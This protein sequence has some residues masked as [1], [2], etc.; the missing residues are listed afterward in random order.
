MKSSNILEGELNKEFQTVAAM[1]AIYCRKHHGGDALC[2]QC[3]DLLKYAESKLDGCPYGEAKPT[4]RKCP[5]HCYRPEPKEQMRRV[6]LY[7]G[8]RMLLSHP[9]LAIR[10][11]LHERKAVPER[12][13]RK[14]SNR[15]RRRAREQGGSH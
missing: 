12:F 11:L 15:Y 14:L 4:C 6:M 5:I 13:G 3:A 2:E 8:P 7:A 9:I 10:H 1:V